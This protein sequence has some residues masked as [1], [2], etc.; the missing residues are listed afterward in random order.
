MTET[1]QAL[2]DKA[3]RALEAAEAN[4]ELD[5]AETSINRAYYAAFYAALAALEAVNEQPK[6]H[7]GT[8]RR[9]HYHFV[10][11]ER[12]ALEIGEILSHAL[13]FRQQVDYDAFTIFDVQA[14]A[15]LSADVH[16]FVAAVET[17][18]LTY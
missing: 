14:A 16:R 6:T 4:V 11:T 13:D 15:D 3:Q 2:L 9:F 10:R 8:L 18:L 1:Q 17:M 12:L 7:H 5:D